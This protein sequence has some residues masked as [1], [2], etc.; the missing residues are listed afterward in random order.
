MLSA[1][2]LAE[3]RTLHALAYG[4]EGKLSPQDG[5]RLRELERQR[6]RVPAARGSETP[7]PSEE[8]VAEPGEVSDGS[9]QPTEQPAEPAEPAEASDGSRRRSRPRWLIAAAA[10]ALLVGLGAGWMIWGW[11]SAE[12]ALAAAHSAQRGDLEATGDDWEVRYTEA[13][14]ETIR[15]IEASEGIDGRTLSILGYDGETA[16]WRTWGPEG[17]CVIAEADAGFIHGCME[18]M[19]ADSDSELVLVADVQGVPTRY[20]VHRTEQ[21]GEQLTVVKLPESGAAIDETGE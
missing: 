2:E 5:A 7:D 9:E 18:E 14:L 6:R 11:N 4:R 8:S 10:G 19:S 15:R 21:R 20:I 3:L 1:E 17:Q 13:E 12:S 16:V